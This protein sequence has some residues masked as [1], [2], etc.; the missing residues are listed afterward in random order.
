MNNRIL[1]VFHGEHSTWG[2]VGENLFL[3]GFALE[4]CY[5]CLG[6][7]LPKSMSGYAGCVVFGGPQSAADDSLPEIR[8]ELAWLE[9]EVLPSETPVLGIC[10]GAQ[11][12]A[13]VLG[14]KVGPA[15]NGRVEI[16]YV[17]IAPTEHGHDFLDAPTV[18]YQWHSETFE[19]PSGAVH[20]AT[21]T[22]FEGQAFS[23]GERVHAIEFHP[24]MT[25]EM[26]HRW[27]HSEVGSK[28]LTLPGAQSAATQL[29]GYRKY[30]SASDQ[31]LSRYLGRVFGVP[32][33]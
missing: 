16:G 15:E 1:A 5:P 3:R 20:L 28:K 10:L 8:A 2:K 4:R 7:P 18:F 6:E 29:A 22:H 25:G 13:R 24:E 21:S 12:L 30:S 11:E 32:S 17:E 9:D 23:Y 19:I 26:V 31:W 14:A 27:S 33:A